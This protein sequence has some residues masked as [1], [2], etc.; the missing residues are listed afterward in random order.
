MN[1]LL[2]ALKKDF[3]KYTVERGKYFMMVKANRENV[4]SAYFDSII[5]ADKLLKC[6]LENIKDNKFLAKR[7]SAILYEKKGF[8]DKKTR[9]GI[10]RTFIN[11]IV[12]EYKL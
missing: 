12:K 6:Y 4:D 1:V 2:G 5:N 3:Q 8:I 9:R 11:E 10:V 7:K